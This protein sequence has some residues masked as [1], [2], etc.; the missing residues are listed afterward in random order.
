MPKRFTSK[1]QAFN[2]KD[3]E[4][5]LRENTLYSSC[6]LRENMANLTSHAFVKRDHKSAKSSDWSNMVFFIEFFLGSLKF[7]KP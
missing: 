4:I 7:C 2:S 1:Y 3:T 5:F 6:F